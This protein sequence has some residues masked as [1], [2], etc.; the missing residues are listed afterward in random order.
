MAVDPQ[1]EARTRRLKRRQHAAA[2]WEQ[3]L[4][5]GWTPGQIR[6]RVARREWQ[7]AFQGVYILGDAAVIPLAA[8][9]AVLLSLG[10][11]AALSRHTAAFLWRQITRRP[12]IIEVTV[13]RSRV[14]A[15]SD[16]RIHLVH[17]LDAKDVRYRHGLA[18]T[19]P[20]RTIIDLATDTSSTVLE[21]ITGDSVAN[22]LITEDDLIAALDRVPSNHPGAARIRA[23]LAEDP[24]FLLQTRSVAER[25]AYPLILDAGLPRPALNEFV[26]GCLVDLHWPEQKLV[27]EVD[28]FQF[29]GSRLAF[30]N[31]RR[32]DQILIAAGYTVIR[33]TW[34]QLTRTPLQV[35]ATVAQALAR[36]GPGA[37]AA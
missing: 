15:R 19:S 6:S 31:D 2:G 7:R 22:R 26:H 5:A 32:R 25:I 4:D 28:S 13:P 10:R 35:I 1:I 12:L 33:V 30:E 36:A 24:E 3:L 17:S 14:R 29:H 18:V 16:V 27:L 11:D 23:R 21:R 9:S 8:E 34:H 37:P 20:A